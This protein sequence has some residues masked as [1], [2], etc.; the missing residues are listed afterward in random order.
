MFW[1]IFL[2]VVFSCPSRCMGGVDLSDALIGYYKVLHKT[3]KWYKTF[4]YHFMDIAIVNAFLLQKDL[5][6]GKGEVPMSQKAFRDTLVEELAEVGSPSTAR[7]V[8]SLAPHGAHHRPVHIAGHSTAGRL[9]CMQCRAK[10]PIKCSSCDV[11]LCFIVTAIMPGMLP[12]KFN[13]CI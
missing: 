10:T 5:A 4:F 1:Y 7:L 11:P 13:I 6:R 2:N 12:I 8:P 9:K 3:M